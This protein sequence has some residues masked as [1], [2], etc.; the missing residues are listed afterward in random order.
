M[1]LPYTMGPEPPMCP[2]L[3]STVGGDLEHTENGLPSHSFP[4]AGRAWVLSKDS[5]FKNKE[6]LVPFWN[7]D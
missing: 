7:D 4:G 5:L 3:S 2:L 1:P 6:E